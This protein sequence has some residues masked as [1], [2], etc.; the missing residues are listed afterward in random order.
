MRRF[1]H[2]CS[3]QA[4]ELEHATQGLDNLDRT[5]LLN[6]ILTANELGRHLRRS[7]RT[8]AS[9][10]VRLSSEE[11]GAVWVEDTETLLLSRHGALLRCSHTAK[12]GQKLQVIRSDTGQKVQARVAWL[13]ASGSAKDGVRLGVEF[14]ACENFWELDWG[15]IEEAR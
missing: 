6:I 9:I 2:E 13:R 8:A 5:K 4:D 3:R 11:P 10:A 12:P 14:V 1:I 15:A 7:P